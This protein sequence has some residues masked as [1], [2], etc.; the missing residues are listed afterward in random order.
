M[1]DIKLWKIL[2]EKRKLRE[3]AVTFIGCRP[4]CLKLLDCSQFPRGDMTSTDSKRLTALELEK[5]AATNAQ[6]D[7]NQAA[8]GFV[9]IEQENDMSTTTP[10]PNS[11]NTEKRSS[12]MICNEQTVTKRLRTEES[13]KKSISKK[14]NGQKSVFKGNKKHKV[15][16]K[17]MTSRIGTSCVIRAED[18]ESNRKPSTKINNAVIKVKKKMPVE[19]KSK[20][21][22]RVIATTTISKRRKQ[23]LIN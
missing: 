4:T 15:S 6:I 20:E 21:K 13:I 16:K 10:I 11:K 3:I 5:L 23:K 12:E 2:H 9:V 18:S 22:L 8:R 19:T 14:K 1:G 7:R 17:N